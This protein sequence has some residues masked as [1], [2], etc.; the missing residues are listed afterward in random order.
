MSRFEL[1]AAAFTPMTASGE[2]NLA[3]VPA[4]VDH[5]L[6]QTC[7]ASGKAAV[8]GL[9]VG[10]STGEFSS[11]TVAERMQVAE[12]YQ[13]AAGERCRMFVHVGCNSIDNSVALAKHAEAIGAPAIGYAPPTYFRP[14]DVHAVAACLQKVA[15]AAPKTQVFYY[16]I[17]PLTGVHIR[18]VDLLPLMA[19]STPNFAGVKFSHTQFDDL[20]RCVNGSYQMLFGADEMLLAGAAIG[21]NGAVGSTYNYFAKHYRRVLHAY[22]EGNM[23]QAQEHQAVA[24]Q[25]V[26]KVLEFGGMSAIKAAMTCA[27]VDVGPPRLPL[28]PLAAEQQSELAQIMGE[29]LAD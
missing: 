18:M 19:E 3:A 29:I 4:L 28:T 16:H 6:G 9:F 11:L 7:E 26:H 23:R 8:D 14:A 17:P 15:A 5:T 20:A 25:A 13:Q 22:E 27:G 24:S 10:G 1:I 2:L 21:A 12:A